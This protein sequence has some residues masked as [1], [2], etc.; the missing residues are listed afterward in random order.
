MAGTKK[1]KTSGK[2]KKTGGKTKAQSMMKKCA[3]AWHK[4]DKKG[5]YTAFVKKFF[6]EHK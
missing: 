2:S 6:R 3:E 4:S 1:T 5:K